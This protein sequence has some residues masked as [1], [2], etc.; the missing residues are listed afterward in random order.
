MERSSHQTPSFG[1][2]LELSAIVD[3]A[4]ATAIKK[5]R[6]DAR[7]VQT[8]IGQPGRIYEIFDKLFS[9]DSTLSNK[10]LNIIPTVERLY[11]EAQSGTVGENR[12]REILD[13]KYSDFEEYDFDKPS[14]PTDETNVL[15]YEVAYQQKCFFDVF[16]S[17]YCHLDRLCFTQAQ[18]VRYCQKYP[19]KLTTGKQTFFLSKKNGEYFV[20]GVCVSNFH[21]PGGLSISTINLEEDRKLDTM[22]VG[23]FHKIVVPEYE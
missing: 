20:A 12:A 19:T 23:Q 10:I 17:F 18:I 13:F 3:K 15:I 1:Q 9:D 16:N 22:C 11:I 14:H 5:N 8:I 4:I 2:G 7:R 6:T 21:K